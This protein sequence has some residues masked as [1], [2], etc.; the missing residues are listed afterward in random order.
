M[1]QFTLKSVLTIEVDDHRLVRSISCTQD[2]NGICCWRRGCFWQQCSGHIRRLSCFSA[3]VIVT[4]TSANA[5]FLRKCQFGKY[6]AKKHIIVTVIYLTGTLLLPF[7][8]FI[9]AIWYAFHVTI[10]LIQAS[11]NQQTVLIQ[12]LVPIIIRFLLLQDE[13][14]IC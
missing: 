6:L 11:S 7:S 8:K 13:L 2:Q 1:A 9:V 12:T 3:W 4:W 5:I 10:A 14:L